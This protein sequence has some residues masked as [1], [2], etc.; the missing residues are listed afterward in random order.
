M[1]YLPI[2][3]I[4]NCLIKNIEFVEE[5]KIDEAPCNNKL[6]E[7]LEDESNPLKEQYAKYI[8]MFKFGVSKGAINIELQKNNL[9]YKTFLELI[10]EKNDK[11]DFISYNFDSRPVEKNS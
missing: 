2:I 11:E 10:G 5:I 4:D 1:I 7:K 9:D 3:K 8:K 6:E